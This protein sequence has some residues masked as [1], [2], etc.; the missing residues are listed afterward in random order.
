MTRN[1]ENNFS[2]HF[3]YFKVFDFNRFMNPHLKTS[4]SFMIHTLIVSRH[5]F[6]L[7]FCLL[8][9]MKTKALKTLL[10]YKS[11]SSVRQITF[12][13]N[14]CLDS[15]KISWYIFFNLF[16]L[17]KPSH[18][19]STMSQPNDSITSMINGSMFI[20]LSNNG[21]LEFLSVHYPILLLIFHFTS[22]SKAS[23]CQTSYTGPFTHVNKTCRLVFMTS[24]SKIISKSFFKINTVIVIVCVFLD[25][26]EHTFLGQAKLCN[27]SRLRACICCTLINFI[28][29]QLRCEVEERENQLSK[30]K[31]VMINSD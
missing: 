31:A 6:F 11:W 2:S 10:S 29:F 14:I 30:E 24:S 23:G 16:Q 18:V 17:N 15:L 26:I 5:K 7:F 21:K 9:M 8:F 28:S 20:N 1:I 3:F 22:F 27:L 4:T 12:N 25:G 13:K 19:K